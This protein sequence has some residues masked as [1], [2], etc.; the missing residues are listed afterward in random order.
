MKFV[1]DKYLQQ[2]LCYVYCLYINI[3]SAIHITYELNIIG[4]KNTLL[5]YFIGGPKRYCN[6]PQYQKGIVDESNKILLIACF[7]RLTVGNVTG[8][9]D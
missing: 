5:Y 6:R 3:K 4:Q 9:I 8:R 1:I 7:Y 2:I